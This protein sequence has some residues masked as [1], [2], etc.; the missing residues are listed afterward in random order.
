MDIHD[1][2]PAPGS[3]RRRKRVG[4]GISAGQGKTCGRG[5]KGD[6][7]RG[8]TRP[9]FEGGQTPLHRRLPRL[10]GFNNIFRRDLNEVNVGRLEV[11]EAGAEIT[12]DVLLEK[13]IIRKLRDGVKIL[14]KGELS[15]KL[16][17]KAT[18]FSKSAVQKI[19]AAGGTAVVIGSDGQERPA[20]A[21]QASA[22]AEPAAA[23]PAVAEEASESAQSPAEA[24][25]ESGD[26]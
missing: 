22:A 18:A 14:G 11:F 10:R 4:R 23:E 15:K 5:T 13:R 16:T 26:E 21:E 7:A 1:L 19:E 25:D 8:Q 12:P 6:K 20:A 3:R 2:S 17:V 24:S 9:G